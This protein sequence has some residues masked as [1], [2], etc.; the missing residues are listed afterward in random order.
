MANGQS[1]LVSNAEN[2]HGAWNASV[3]PRTGNASFSLTVESVLF[4]HGEGRHDLQLSYAGG[5][6][7]KGP[8][9]FDLGVHWQWNTGRE[10]PSPSEVEGHLTTD[11][12]TGDGHRFTMVS[13]RNALGKTIWHPLRHKLGDVLITGHPGDWMIATA[14]GIRQHIYKG[15]EDWEENRSGQRIYFYYDR[16]EPR[17]KTRHLTW[18]CSHQLS[19]KEQ[20]STG[21]LC[22]NEG[23]RL[24]YRGRDVIIDGYRRVIIHRNEINGLHLINQ[25]SLP[26]LSSSESER[27][28]AT[29]SIFFNYDVQGRRPWLLRQI[30]Y[31]TGLQKTFLYNGEADYSKSQTR[32][33]PVGVND[34][35][36]PV[37]TEEITSSSKA[38]GTITPIRVWYNYGSADNGQGEHNYLGYQG[39]H[40]V[41]PGKD[42]LFDRPGS[43]TYSVTRDDGTTMITTTYN[44]YHLPLSVRQYDSQSKSLLALSEQHYPSWRQTTFSQ[45][46]ANYSLAK[47]KNQTLYA[48]SEKG[49]ERTIVPARV[50]QSSEYN[51]NGQIIWQKDPYGR[52]KM[53]Q[54]CPPAG[55][56]H[57]P[58][59]DS[60][61]PQVTKPEKI[62]ILP[63]TQ[64][65]T[66]SRP[67]IT[68]SKTEIT[69]EAREIVFD[70]MRLPAV[71][72]KSSA[73]HG[74]GNLS[75]FWQVR[76]KT[77]GTVP[78][79]QVADLKP[80]DTLPELKPEQLSSQTLYEYNTETGGSTYGKMTRLT[81]INFPEAAPVSVQG[82]LL[83][84]ARAAALAAPAE[85]ASFNIDN[86]IDSMTNT[87]T[88]TVSVAP[89]MQTT[90]NTSTMAEKAGMQ[91]GTTVYS[92]KTGNKLASHDTL[93]T[94]ATSWKYDPWNRPLMRVESP[95]NGGYPRKTRWTYI[96]SP[97]ENAIIKTLPEGEQIKTVL[98]VM[99]QEISTSH[100]FPVSTDTSK[101]GWVPDTETT[102]TSFGKVH[103]RVK[104]HA[105]DPASDGVAG[106]A[107]ALKTTYGYDVLN[108][109][110]WVHSPD[111][112][113]NFTI[114]DDPHMLILT[115]RTSVEFG[116]HK[117]IT[118]QMLKVVQSNILG[119]PVAMYLLPLNQNIKKRGNYLYSLELKQELQQLLSQQTPASQ[120]QSQRSY[121]LLPVTGL[122]TFVQ[123]ALAQHAWLTHTTWSYDGH[124]RKVSQK[125]G[126]GVVTHWFYEYD[127]L[128][129]TTTAD[130]R[131]IH[132]TFNV[133]GDK[134]ARCVQPAGIQMC[135]VTG[136]RSYDARG[137]IRWEAD[138]YGQKILY[139]HDAN[140]RLLK[141]VTPAD[142]DTSHEHIFTWQYNSLGLT[143][144]ILD[145][146]IQARYRYDPVTWKLT[147]SDDAISHTHYTYAPDTGALQNVT[148]STPDKNSSIAP[149][150]GIHY[151]GGTEMVKLD[152]YLQ[153]VSMTDMAGNTYTTIHDK[154]GRSIETHV[155]LPHT[156]APVLL[157]KTSYDAFGRPSVITNGIQMH[158]QF[159]YDILGQVI[160][161]H[162]YHQGTL[163]QTLAYTYDPETHNML[164]FTRAAGSQ[165][166]TQTYHYDR[167]NNLDEMHCTTT[168]TRKPSDLCPR[169]TDIGHSQFTTPPII[170]GQRYSFDR[171]NNIQTVEETGVAGT[172]DAGTYI[173]KTTYTYAGAGQ[174]ARTSDNYDPHR[175]TNYQTRWSNQLYSAS[176]EKI[177][178]DKQGRIIR[179]ADGNQLHYDA[180]GQQDRFINVHTHEVTHYTYDSDGHMVAA[181]PFDSANHLL[182]A[183]LYMLYKGDAVVAEIQ[184]SNHQQHINVE[185][186]GVA[187]SENG[188]IT[189]WYLRDY[190]GDLLTAFNA[191]GVKT[192][193]N[194]Y[195][196]YGMKYN[197]ISTKTQVFSRALAQT[198]QQQWW[199]NHLPGFNNQM[200]DPATGY[201]FLG[202][203]YRAYNPVYRRFMKR[204]SFSPFK[205]IDGYGFGQNNPIMNTDPSG[206][207]HKE[208]GYLSGI[209]GIGM[210]VMMTALI[211]VTAAGLAVPASVAFAAF[212][213][214]LLTL[215][216][217]VAN[218]ASGSLQIAAT[219]HPEKKDLQL[220]NL[221]MGIG[222]IFA[223]TYT[224]LY[225]TKMSINALRSIMRSGNGLIQKRKNIFYNFGTAAAGITALASHA[226]ATL[227][228]IPGSALVHHPEQDEK[229]G[230]LKTQKI[231]MMVSI[232]SMAISILSGV[233]VLSARGIAAECL[234]R[235][236]GAGQSQI[237]TEEHASLAGKPKATAFPA[238]ELKTT[239]P[240]GAKSTPLLSSRPDGESVPFVAP[241]D[242]LQTGK[243]SMEYDASG[244][245]EYNTMPGNVYEELPT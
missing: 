43:Y 84:P 183:P 209:L 22:G 3:D 52:I 76:R 119:K 89:T 112:Q 40:S 120:L 91:L 95:V 33:L 59:A 118:D 221:L 129:A 222:A 198:T 8:D 233:L 115:Y 189:R 126:N 5:P 190:K 14:T 54:Y 82:T 192:A 228:V 219:A 136:T 99:G 114:R 75:F 244:E 9:S 78:V 41:Q 13:D 51:S 50:M 19:L 11:I 166:A 138:A 175:L 18:M 212:S 108:R 203:G 191:E 158:R 180:S 220:A 156:T 116:T 39:S 146:R 206:H 149:V 29:D 97:R 232:G 172:Q 178:C 237:N 12:I 79:A 139:E 16:E 58:P 6:S 96:A 66:G 32:G 70:Y 135:H 155:M 133:R 100:R 137:N 240:T 2:F 215:P 148:H 214:S 87:R 110:T 160:S 98:N 104:W 176:P 143:A 174:S 168:N 241:K 230:W 15:Y 182:Q 140:G 150:P 186:G 125:A 45:L 181:Q 195:S 30:T 67:F 170:T 106:K 31:P 211:P 141:M 73:G 196:P 200:S 184:E 199:K 27:P 131:I 93:K 226:A 105:D 153:I 197:R 177:T 124:G 239:T 24:T 201:Q 81:L 193:E 17:N 159:T 26:S 194:L 103:T 157:T 161:T 38:N 128:V 163:I 204:D 245:K 144:K 223:G 71:A 101:T 130:G 173:K 217:N 48:L 235:R 202:G 231:L 127:H 4:N 142:S 47:S 242:T 49:Q 44:K 53:T 179:D 46:P 21:N 236:S 147:D 77:S 10:Y 74:A 60:I 56:S 225:T 188:Q 169:D 123:K 64:S 185:L 134:T 28:G 37:V 72:H 23:V 171:W 121:G 145:G 80:G 109:Q 213:S 227:N 34:A 187:H 238:K 7:P 122:L 63:A 210:A 107:I 164:T 218:I 205:E 224:G 132:D 167:Q 154:L 83:L 62:L 57:C 117:E 35:H 151:P 162:D 69:T 152:R 42:N 25:I 208:L 207:M 90:K 61:W 86:Q 20:K 55:N 36:L 102:Y 113:I 88:T 229:N 216:A 65:P 165:S 243:E 1:A 85:K 68:M 234:S 94:M 111:G 92:L